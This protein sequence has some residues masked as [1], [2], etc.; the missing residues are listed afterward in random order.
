MLILSIYVTGCSS[1]RQSR[2]D[3]P[4][5]DIGKE[6]PEKE[7]DLTHIA[8]VTYLYLNAESDEYLYKG[9]IDYVS[10]NKIVVIDRASGSVLFFSK[11]GN[12][13]SRFNRRGQGPEEYPSIYSVMYDETTDDVY[14][15]PD[16]SDFV[17]V[18]SS[19]GEYKRKLT[20]PQRNI[21]GQTVIFDD[22]SILV[23]DDS[24]LWQNIMKK[25]VEDHSDFSEQVHDSS[26]FLIS[27]TDGKVLDYIK[28][29]TNN[30]DISSKRSNVSFGLINYGRVR[31]CPDGLFLYNP[32]TD[33]V[34]LY[35]KDKS[36]TPYM[37]KEP[38][39]SNLDIKMVMDI[40]MDAGSFQFMSVIPYTE[41]GGSSSVKY[42]MRDKKTG[43]IFRQK[44]IIPDYQGKEFFIDPRQQNYYET[45]CHIELD[46]I[47]LKEA[48]RENRLSG[49]LKELA[50]NLNENED[51]NIFMLIEFK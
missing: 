42:Y 51:N 39:L 5:I 10:K 19:T 21:N 29:T 37:R 16:F 27:N 47:E 38:L 20:L 50:A 6:Y 24:R 34:F 4:Y 33:T 9:T 46:L 28:M 26:F 31:K 7:I 45:G 15:T 17:N 13:T 12:P 3:L 44:L 8:D 30:I 23:Y 49:Q 43:E 25:N 18:Y 22:R 36:L 40:C 2:E 41:T 35:G 32:E 14:V 11:S 1:D 48:Y